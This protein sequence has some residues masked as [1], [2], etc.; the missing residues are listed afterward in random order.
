MSPKVAERDLRLAIRYA[1]NAQQVIDIFHEGAAEL[2]VSP[3][4]ALDALKPYNADLAPVRR[5]RS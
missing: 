3:M 4:P 2:M 5:P 1:V